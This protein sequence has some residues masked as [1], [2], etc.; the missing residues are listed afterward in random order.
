VAEPGAPGPRAARWLVLALAGDEQTDAQ[1]PGGGQHG[2]SLQAEAVAND[3]HPLYLIA[4]A[5][6][7]EQLRRYLAPFAQAG[8]VE[9]LPASP[10][11]AVINRGF[12]AQ[13][14][15]NS[16]TGTPDQASSPGCP[17]QLAAGM[18]RTV[19]SA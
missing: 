8:S 2:G 3:K 12:C 15:A 6:D 18:M 11:E 9:V 7:E 10:C 5:G 16:T 1:G 13:L 14:A 19:A 17:R 4:E